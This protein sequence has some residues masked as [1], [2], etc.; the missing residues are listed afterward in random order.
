MKL[1]LEAVFFNN[2]IGLFTK[3]N[4]SGIRTQYVNPKILIEENLRNGPYC[5]LTS[6]CGKGAPYLEVKKYIQRNDNDNVVT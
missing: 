6:E 1:S 4:K 3:T 5:T 2:C